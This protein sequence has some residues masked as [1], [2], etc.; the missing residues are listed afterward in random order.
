MTPGFNVEKAA[1]RA[2]VV[3]EYNTRLGLNF[4][5]GW[6]DCPANPDEP[7]KIII[8][9]ENPAVSAIGKGLRFKNPGM[10]LNFTGGWRARLDETAV[11]EFG[12]ALGLVHEQRRSS[13][14]HPHQNRACADNP[15]GSQGNWEGSFRQ[16][17]MLPWDRFS[18][19]NY[20]HDIP[21]GTP[22]TLSPLDIEGIARLYE[23]ENLYRINI[24]GVPFFRETVDINGDSSPDFCRIV[25]VPMTRRFEVTC[26]LSDPVSGLLR[27]DNDHHFRSGIMGVG[28]GPNSEPISFKGFA[29]VDG[30]S[31]EDFCRFVGERHALRMACAITD[32]VALE[33][34]QAEFSSDAGIDPGIQY[35]RQ[36]IVDVN[37]D[38]RADYCRF[39]QNANGPRLSCTLADPSLREFQSN[40]VEFS[41]IDGIDMGY[42]QLPAA[43]VDVNGDGRVEFCRYVGAKPNIHRSCNETNSTLTG[44]DNNQY[45]ISDPADPSAWYNRGDDSPIVAIH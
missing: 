42:P 31:V 12:H 45:G 5:A 11:H 6:G 15:Q 8:N 23:I 17:T 1:V 39:R 37:D 13:T 29:D 22:G 26:Q 36:W 41:S 24:F 4:F 3:R 21:R 27:N 43:I 10:Q 18:I 38:G 44:F 35:R 7:I 32:P 25:Q 16:Q 19:M 33:F 34:E 20:C 2:A 14:W 9:N 28:Y 30:D 40:S